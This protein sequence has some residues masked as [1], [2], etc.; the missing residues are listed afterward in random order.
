[1]DIEL[2][3][4]G[5]RSFARIGN[6]GFIIKDFRISKSAGD[7]EIRAI[8]EDEDADKTIQLNAPTGIVISQ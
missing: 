7:T 2:Y 5:N 1:M 6:K 4:I 3:W 8:V